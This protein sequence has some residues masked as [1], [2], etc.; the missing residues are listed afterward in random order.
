MPRAGPFPASRRWRPSWRSGCLRSDRGVALL[1]RRE[2]DRAIAVDVARQP[3]DRSEHV[4][5]GKRLAKCLARIGVEHAR[6]NFLGYQECVGLAADN[7]CHVVETGH[8]VLAQ[9]G[10]PLMQA[11]KRQAV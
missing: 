4:E 2:G 10:K 11:V 6:E 9:L 5:M 7:G 1:H 3:P 8:M